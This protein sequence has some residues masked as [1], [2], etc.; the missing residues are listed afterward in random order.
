MGQA[1]TGEDLRKVFLDVA[2]I[3]RLVEIDRKGL[4]HAVKTFH[5]TEL[6]EPKSI[7]E[8]HLC[9]DCAGEYLSQQEQQASPPTTLAGALAH[10]GRAG[11]PP[12]PLFDGL[13]VS[14]L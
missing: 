14:L 9:E 5:I 6:T 12:T 11:G 3:I 4:Q 10:Y 1:G 2:A 7:R 8:V 13:V